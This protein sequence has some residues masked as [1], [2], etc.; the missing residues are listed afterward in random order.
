MQ[1]HTQGSVGTKFYPVPGSKVYGFSKRPKTK[2][3]RFHFV[4]PALAANQ[5]NIC[6]LS[7]VLWVSLPKLSPKGE[8]QL[9]FCWCPRIQQTKTK[10]SL[11]EPTQNGLV[12]PPPPCRHR[13]NDGWWKRV[14]ARM[15]AHCYSVA[16]PNESSI[17]ESAKVIHHFPWRETI[18]IFVKNQNHSLHN[19]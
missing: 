2:P 8:S 15:Q 14:Q 7:I 3:T 16:G 12:K 18:I 6:D 10:Q 11:T 4:L 1:T 5:Q 17:P 13:V 19:F 9:F